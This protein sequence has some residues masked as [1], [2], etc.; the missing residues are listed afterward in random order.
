MKLFFIALNR[1]MTEK[2]LEI[3]VLTGIIPDRLHTLEKVLNRIQ[4]EL[5]G[6][7]SMPFEKL[8]TIHFC[9]WV[10]IEKQITNEK[11]YPERLIFAGN[12][13]GESKERFLRDLCESSAAL[14]DE[15]YSNCVGYPTGENISISQRVDYL[16]KNILPTKTFFVAAPARTVERIKS[17]HELRNRLRGFLDSK[18]FSGERPTAI[19]SALR[20]YTE[21]QTDLHWAKQRAPM[22]GTNWGALILLAIILIPLLPFVILLI[23]LL[24]IFA[25][26]RE[27]PLGIEPGEL[28]VKRMKN[29][30]QYEDYTFQNQLSQIFPLKTTL[31]RRISMNFVLTLTQYLGKNFFD[32]GILMGIPT[33][34]FAR[35]IVMDDSK[36]MMFF[37]NFDGSWQQYLG[38]FIDKSGWGLTGIYSATEGFPKSYF[39]FFGGAY[40]EEQFLAWSRY[41]QIPTQFWYSAYPSLSIKN[42]INNSIIRDD[43]FRNLSES[44]ALKYLQRI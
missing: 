19:H 10:I 8:N 41:Y 31:L 43:L 25:E 26:P 14:I 2:Q 11:E 35:W 12:F 13:D 34:H 32:K 16:G 27:I 1:A 24:R 7:Q 15:I 20:E 21:S 22:P 4:A 44:K 38:D 9:R 42:V 29:L 5:R 36:H 23:L 17:E 6:G 30:E 33:I 39:L 40:N 37:S 3:N 28:G 18:D